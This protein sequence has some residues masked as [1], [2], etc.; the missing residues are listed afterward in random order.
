MNLSRFAL[1]LTAICTLSACL[2]SE[3]EV[4]TGAEDFAMLCAPCHGSKGDG[5]GDFGDSLGK[6]PAN[7]TTLAVRNGG[8]FPMARV[9]SKIWGYAKEDGRVMPQFAPLLETGMVL[10]DSGDGIA[11]PTPLRL[12][13][14]AEYLKTLQE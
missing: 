12:V 13:Q 11:T 14:L 1:C 7:L 8:K 5:Q 3:P 4:P 6:K 9:M 2:P 10:F